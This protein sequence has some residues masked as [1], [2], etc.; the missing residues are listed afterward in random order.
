MKIKK[1]V[2][3]MGQ[4]D[5]DNNKWSKFFSYTK[6]EFCPSCKKNL[7]NGY[8]WECEYE[9][10]EKPDI[11][12]ENCVDVVSLSELIKVYLKAQIGAM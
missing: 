4:R 11:L 5:I 2:L 6:Q 8:A 1:R 7:Y 3:F 9:K 12:C 10:K